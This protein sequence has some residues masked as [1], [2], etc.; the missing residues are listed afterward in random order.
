MDDYNPREVEKRWQKEWEN[1]NIYRTPTN[2]NNRKFY[3][4]DFFP[5]PSGDGL[6]VGHLRNYIPTDV[7]SRYKKMRKFNVLHPMG[8]DAFGLP[9]ENEAINKGLHPR[10]TV[11][12][13]I[14]NYKHQLKLVGL[15][16]DWDKE[17]NSSTP[18]YYKWTQWYFLLLYDRGLAYRMKSAVNFCPKCGTVLAREEVENGMCWRCHTDLIKIEREQWY[19]KITSYAD[20]LLEDLDLLDWPENIIEMQ[21]NW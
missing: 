17:L 21:K 1:D 14:G 15:S 20:R 6:S 9:A 4:L 7:I 5:Y 8:W 3:C 11:P 10:E 18:E 16:Y 2:K 19:F 12:R 13:Y